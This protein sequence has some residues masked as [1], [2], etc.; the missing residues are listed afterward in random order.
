MNRSNIYQIE[1]YHP[2]TAD[3]C[4]CDYYTSPQRLYG[5]DLVPYHKEIYAAVRDEAKIGH[6]VINLIDSCKDLDLVD[7]VIYAEPSVKKIKDELVGVTT[8]LT[9]GQLEP[10]A[11]NRLCEYLATE[12]A[13]GWGSVMEQ[14]N[15]STEDGCLTLHYWNNQNKCSFRVNEMQSQPKNKSTSRK[16]E[17]YER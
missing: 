3:L 1:L 9:K 15:I 6:Q 12:Y 2:L 8:I 14:H 4:S 10:T 7:K 16:K 11:L 5:K 17:V 13:D